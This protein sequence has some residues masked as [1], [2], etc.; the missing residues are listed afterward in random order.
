MRRSIELSLCLCMFIQDV[1]SQVLPGLSP[2]PTAYECELIEMC[3]CSCLFFRG[4]SRT[5]IVC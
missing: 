4:L 2:L 3:A 1:I 5:L